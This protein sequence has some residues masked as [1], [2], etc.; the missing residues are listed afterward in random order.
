[1]VDIAKSHGSAVKFPGSGGAV[2]GLCLDH[3]KMVSLHPARFSNNQGY[4]G[5]RVCVTVC[6]RVPVRPGPRPFYIFPS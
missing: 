1:M 4:K 5:V 2:V 3:E 6:E